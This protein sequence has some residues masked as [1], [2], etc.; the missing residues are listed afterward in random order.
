MPYSLSR[1]LDLERISVRYEYK[2]F[3]IAILEKN[4]KFVNFAERRRSN[5]SLLKKMPK[6]RG[7]PS[8]KAASLGK[9]FTTHVVC[10]SERQSIELEQN[11]NFFDGLAAIICA[12][13]ERVVIPSQVRFV[14]PFCKWYRRFLKMTFLPDKYCRRQIIE[15]E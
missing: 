11:E 9:E 4:V 1:I 8:C 12:P 10:R 14:C 15:S 2:R 13:I 3:A 5:L 6:F 7:N